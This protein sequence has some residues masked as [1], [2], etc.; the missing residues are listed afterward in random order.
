MS[1]NWQMFSRSISGE[2]AGVTTEAFIQLLDFKGLQGSAAAPWWQRN[3]GW[4]DHF[5]V[6]HI[7]TF[8]EYIN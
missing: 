1:K 5:N 4:N 7:K 6:E 8:I 3:M 2:G